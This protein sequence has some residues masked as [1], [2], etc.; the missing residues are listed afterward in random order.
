MQS[1]VCTDLALITKGLFRIY[2]VH[3]ETQE[4]KNIFFFSETA[5]PGIIPQLC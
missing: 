4:E 1:F 5:V 3:P 2:F